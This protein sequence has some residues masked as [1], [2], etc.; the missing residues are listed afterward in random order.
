MTP[1]PLDLNPAHVRTLQEVVR[2]GSF[3]RAADTPALRVVLA[4]LA[5]LKRKTRSTGTLVKNR[6]VV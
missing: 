1:G 3:S 5:A 6:S 2:R 4:A